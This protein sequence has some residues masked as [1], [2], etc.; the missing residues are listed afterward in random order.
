MG[1]RKRRTREYVCFLLS[2]CMYGGG[3]KEAE[4]GNER[5]KEEERV[6]GLISHDAEKP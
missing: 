5:E 4:A 6:V 1:G 2:V 3:K